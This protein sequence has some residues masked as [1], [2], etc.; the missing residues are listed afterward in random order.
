MSNLRNILNS[1]A[2]TFGAA[3]EISMT[4]PASA[5]YRLTTNMNVIPVQDFAHIVLIS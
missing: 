2:R 4:A 1:V 5:A 3:G